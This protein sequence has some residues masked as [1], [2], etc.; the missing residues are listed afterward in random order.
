MYTPPSTGRR[1][2]IDA[3]VA[4]QQ[5]VRRIIAGCAEF[6]G[7]ELLIPHKVLE[8]VPTR[9]RRLARTR[10]RRITVFAAKEASATSANTRASTEEIEALAAMRTLALADAFA[11]WASDE[12]QRNDGLWTLAPESARGE[13]LVEKMIQA[14]IARA[15]DANAEEDAIVAGQA[16]AA[17]CRWIASNNLDILGGA[18]FDRWLSHEQGGDDQLASVGVPLVLG[19]DEAIE[20]ILSR[21][22]DY[23]EDR[24]LLSAIAWELARPNVA[25]RMTGAQRVDNL[26]RFANALQ[27]GGAPQAARSIQI[28]LDETRR[29]PETTARLFEGF[30]L[31]GALERTRGAEHRQVN[32]ERETLRDTDPL[33]GIGQAQ[34]RRA[35]PDGE[36]E[37]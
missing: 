10:A 32:A 36:P 24:R 28:T 19:P 9:Y 13:L 17:G 23:P 33:P 27:A 37:K 26:E 4:M 6:S 29:E 20:T 16:I 8:L 7:D 15:E 1:W 34:M 30:N 11:K 12:T 3:N 14:G 35:R 2:A 18:A 22:Y 5:G 21:H 31:A 25:E